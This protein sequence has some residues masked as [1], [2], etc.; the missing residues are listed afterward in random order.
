MKNEQHHRTTQIAHLTTQICSS[1][2]S[3]LL[4]LQPN[5]AHLTTQIWSEEEIFG[6]FRPMHN[7]LREMS[8]RNTVGFNRMVTELGSSHSFCVGPVSNSV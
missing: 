8:A 7:M 5:F 6:G 2:N 1:Y 4:I 3:N